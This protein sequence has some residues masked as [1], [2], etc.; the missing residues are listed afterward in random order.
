MQ[1]PG[2]FDYERWLY[3][4]G[5]VATGYIKALEIRPQMQPELKPESGSVFADL[6]HA[7]LLAALTLGERAG[8]TQSQWA[9]LR[10]TG[11]I[12]LV[13]VSG[14]HVGIL[15]AISFFALYTMLRLSPRSLF[16]SPR[17]HARIWAGLASVVVIA[18]YTVYIGAAAPVV[19]ASVMAG[20]AIV[21]LTMMRPLAWWRI[22]AVGLTFSI[23]LNPAVVLQDGFYLSFIAVG[24]LLWRFAPSMR[25]SSWIRNAVIC[26]IVLSMGLSPWVGLLTGEIPGVSALA[27]IIVVPPMTLLIIPLAMIGVF[28]AQLPFMGACAGWLLLSAD[29]GVG[30][31]L[32]VL[33]RL[34]GSLPVFGPLTWPLAWIAGCGALLVM[35]PNVRPLLCLG[36]AAWAAAFYPIRMSIPAGEVRVQILD[37][38]QGSAAIIDTATRRMFVD[39]GSRFPGG[40]DLAAAIVLPVQRYTGPRRLDRI[41]LTH[42]D[43]DH[44]GGLRA[45][46]AAFPDA[47]VIA[48]DQGCLTGR[49][50]RW[51]EVEFEL[52]THA[53]GNSTNDRSCTLIIATRGHKVYFAGDIGRAAEARLLPSLPSSVDLLIAPHHGSETSSHGAF[54]RHTRP[55]FVVFSVGKDNRY[56]HP[57]ARVV[58]RYGD[59]GSARFS[60]AGSGALTWHSSKAGCLTQARAGAVCIEAQQ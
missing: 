25:K 48:P 51:D 2:A 21:A 34:A 39:V 1:N 41:L 10:A 23:L 59:V 55:R 45:V 28:A 26:Q 52:L 44:A 12:H 53:Q 14:L 4:Q 18:L 11:T 6:V 7:G 58:E 16:V 8:V 29:V 9:L 24:I 37:V 33:D 43:N 56:G 13:V 20:A 47:E 17:C 22:Y 42:R 36:I 5:Y 19:R 50:W 54:V 3:G 30:I 31:I 46:T 32:G 60:T 38:G 49:T 57:R 35:T 40:F 27:N 15:G